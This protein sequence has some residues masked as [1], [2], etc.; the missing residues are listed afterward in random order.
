MALTRITKGVIKPNENYDTHNINSTGIITATAFVGPVTGAITGTAALA[1]GLTGTPSITVQDVVGVGATF[2][3]NVSIGGTLTYEDVTNIDSVGL[4]TARN[5]IDC[6]GDIDVDGHTNLDNVSIAGVTTAIGNLAIGNVVPARNLH[7]KATTPYIRVESGAANQPATLELYHTRGNGSDKWTA[8]VAT[9]DAAL[10][11]N[12][13][14]AANGAPAEKVRIASDGKVGIGTVTP[15]APL[16]VFSNTAATDK[17]LFMVRSATGAFAVQCSS[18]AAANPEWRLRTYAAEDIVFSPGG[19]GSSG[20]KVRIKSDGKVGIG[21]D[22]P[23]TKLEVN[24]A[25]GTRIRS[26]YTNTSSSRDAGF[27]IWADDSG[28]FAARASLVHS[29]SGG[30]TS[31]YAQNQFKLYSDQSDPT[32]FATRAGKVGVNTTTPSQQFT[33]YAA[34]GYPIVANGPSNGIGLGNNGAIVFGNKDLGAYAKGILDGTELEIKLSGT[35]KVNIIAGRITVVDGIKVDIVGGIF[36]RAVTDSFTLNTQVQPHYGFNLSSSSSVPIGMSGYY[37]IAF[38]TEGVER[39]RIQRNGRVGIN[40]TVPT[41]PLNVQAENSTGTCV[42]L[43]QEATNKKAS[44]YFQ[45]A[46]TTGNDSWI[47]NENYDLTVYAGYGGK[48]NLGA[49]QTTGITVLSTG[50][51]GIATASPATTLDVQGDM[52]VAYNATHALRFYTQPKNNWSSISNTATDGNANLSFK[53]AQGEA[54]FI[55]YSKNVGIGENDPASKLHVGGTNNFIRLGSASLAGENNNLVSDYSG[56][57]IVSGTPWY[58]TGCY[59]YNTNK[60]PAMDYYWIKLVDSIASSG[61]AYIEYIATGDTNYPRSVRGTIEVLKYSNATINICHDQQTAEKSVVQLVIDSNQDLW[62]RFHGYDWNHDF[63]F[64]SIYT[65]GVTLNSDFTVGTNA[66]SSG[67]MRNSDAS[68]PNASIDIIPG[69]NIRWNLSN[70]NPPNSYYSNDY[71]KF[72]RV[73]ISN[74]LSVTGSVSKGSGSF[75][76]P[77]PLVGLSTTKDLVHS[78]IEGPQCDNIYRGKVDLVGG[79]ATVNIDTK[80]GMSVGTFVALNRDVQCFTT[81]ETGWTNVKGT[82]SGNT[83]TITAQD[84]SCTDTVSWMVVGERQD[85]IIKSSDLTDNDGNLIL[86]PARTIENLNGTDDVV[87]PD[88]FK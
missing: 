41:S 32:I 21:D 82:V 73:N 78:F 17:D 40:S 87:V 24:S 44:I 80:A 84:N 39:L 48:L 33:S 28:T 34:S 47:T 43:N 37:G 49:Y 46:T 83:L 31:L 68:P 76:I 1:S 45:D 71:R 38:A 61:L 75:K 11:F 85:D 20:E 55:T 81:N 35:A 56:N 64:R 57:P 70:A 25:T 10:T 29:G 5:G 88:E 53:S 7:V 18:I 12:V 27:D 67:R 3:G 6:N 69:S 36:G 15:N 65:E 51:V 16:D 23:A 4:I 50:K 26:S 79:T 77:H 63:R 2:T 9:D 60:S 22:A 8:S 42:R 72:H 74:N 66:A 13:G 62:I 14:N 58:T 30:L 52:A 19:T 54:M 59:N 86:E